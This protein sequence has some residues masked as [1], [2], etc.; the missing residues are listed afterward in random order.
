M[1]KMPVD[2][3]KLLG[4]LDEV[5]AEADVPVA[6]CVV[7]D[8][9]APQR[10]VDCMLDAFVS[11]DTKA[12][13]EAIVLDEGLPDISLPC[14]LCVIVGGTSPALGDVAHVARAKGI[15]A[16]VAIERGS[17]F[18]ATDDARGTGVAAGTA[19]DAA[20]G[21]GASQQGTRPRGIPL[22]DIVDVSFAADIKR[23]LEELG[24]WVVKNAP[25]KR[26]AIAACFPFVRHALAIELANE[27]AVQNGAIGLV[28]FVPGADMPLITLN[29]ARMVMQIAAVYGY[30]LTKERI[31]ELAAVV[32]GGF[33]LRAVARRLVAA[34]PG[35]GW[36]VKPGVA[37]SGT[38]AMAQAAIA[39]FEDEAN[40][41][42]ADAA[43]QKAVDIAHAVAS[44]V[45]GAV[46]GMHVTADEPADGASADDGPAGAVGQA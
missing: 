2:I 31:R 14:D 37:V 38:L 23:P 9:T 5:G 7:F 45:S 32:A 46:A 12:A 13:V 43:V 33:G 1:S 4:S 21:Q 29:Q 44:S 16:V 27:N 30:P 40:V 8:P 26:L 34:A 20:A 19:G 39:Y 17:V 25:A 28:F 11:I 6:V 35:V 18:F 10:L 41:A 42:R 24:S 3:G 36:L 22:D 15:P